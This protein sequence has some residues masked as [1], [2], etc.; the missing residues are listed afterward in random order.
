MSDDIYP[1][2]SAVMIL[3]WLKRMIDSDYSFRFS[4]DGVFL[5][6][7]GGVHEIPFHDVPLM[8]IRSLYHD[9]EYYTAEADVPAK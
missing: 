7:E 6:S 3:K 2:I 5:V 4:T 8:V 1:D 9:Y